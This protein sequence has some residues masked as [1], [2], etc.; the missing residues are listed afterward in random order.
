MGSKALD[1]HCQ[2][3]DKAKLRLEQHLE[4]VGYGICGI[5]GIF[6][7]SG[8]SGICGVLGFIREKKLV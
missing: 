2:Q 5:C 7:I 6:G 1:S 8:I 3:L 4:W